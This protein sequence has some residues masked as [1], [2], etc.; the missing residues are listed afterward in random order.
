MLSGYSVLERKLI[1]K[2]Y[3][4]IDL[5]QSRFKHFTFFVRRNRI[6]QI[7]WNFSR[8]THTASKKYGF[9]F[10]TLHSEIH[11]LIGAK[12]HREDFHRIKV[13]NVRINNLGEV[14]NAMPCVNCGPVLDMY[15]FKDI[16]YTGEDGMFHTWKFGG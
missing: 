12:P 16:F 15:G 11:A 2:S 10:E 5:P 1:D 3:A 8:R 6:L 7:G 14:A 9:R 4:L 13:Y